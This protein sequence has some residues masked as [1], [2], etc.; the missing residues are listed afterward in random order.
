[1]NSWWR[2]LAALALLGAACG[3]P[4]T[5]P[6][7]AV[8]ALAPVLVSDLSHLAAGAQQQIRDAHA[9]ATQAPRETTDASRGESYG[10]LGMLLL[11]V[12][13]P[14]AAEPAFINAATLVPAD[15]RWRYYLA[16]AHRLTHQPAKALLAFEHV[17]RLEP[18]HLPSLVWMGEL[19]LASGDLPAA[20]R[21]FTAALDVEPRAVA[22]LFGRGRTALAAGD[23]AGAIRDLRKALTADPDAG[24]IHYPLAMAY[25]AAG[26]VASAEAHVR[27]RPRDA[28]P[29]TP[30]DPLLA[31]LS[32]L[33]QNA[34][35]SE[36]RGMD[37]LERRDWAQAV[38]HLR[39][40]VTAAPENAVT[41]LNLGT[42][43]YLSGDAAAARQALRESIRL[44]PALAKGHYA[45]GVLLEAEGDDRAAI[46]RFM[47]AV[48]RDPRYLEAHFS[49][50]DAL[51]RTGR[52]E[53]ALTHYGQVLAINPAASQARFGYGMALVRLGRWRAARD[54][55]AEGM[56]LHPDQPGFAHAL[57]RVLA[58]APDA[59]ARDG[60]RALALLEGPLRH[61]R[62][63]VAS[64]TMAMA[65]A[66]LGRYTEA[67]EWQQA[68]IGAAQTAN[69][70]GAADRMRE[71][72]ALYVRRRPCRTPWHAADPIHAPGPPRAVRPAT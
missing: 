57:A 54:R 40:A 67:V 66:E 42:A 22:A 60:A 46:D 36:A 27:A 20:E 15:V 26:D 37:A 3:Q 62:T 12:E 39:E 65:L 28:E 70:R 1:M 17:L 52:P 47:A 7:R 10:A 68:A 51:R 56:R 53:A 29:P 48:E 24:A 38:R 34:A 33:V 6:R 18:G 30:P 9:S 45:L 32:G 8:A 49:L 44:A 69:D 43:L 21:H 63:A 35:A 2:W 59:D 16:H 72:L 41:H 5:P 23:H 55:L 31:R 13:L 25:R 61:H 50:G 71:T 58:A 14:E 19:S 11:A 64:E 4:A